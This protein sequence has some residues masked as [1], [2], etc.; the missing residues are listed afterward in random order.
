MALS[1]E[2]AL[3]GWECFVGSILF[4]GHT[5]LDFDSTLIQNQRRC[6]E[7]QLLSMWHVPHYFRLS[8]YFRPFCQALAGL[9]EII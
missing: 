6:L 9:V 4:T 3:A 1:S 7:I 5:L 8:Q 2:H